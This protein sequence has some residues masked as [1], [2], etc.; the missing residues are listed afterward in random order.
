MIPKI[1][2]FC[3]LSGDRYPAKIQYC[4]DSWKKALPD[5]EI[6]LWDLN[7]F[8]I[9][10]SVW[11]KEAFEA[12]KYAFA[13]D[14]IRCLALYTYGGI[15]LDSDVEV[16]KPFDDLLTLPYF[17]GEEQ[18]GNLEPAVMGCEKGWPVMKKMLEY[19]SGRHFVTDGKFDMETL[20]SLMSAIIRKDWKY[21]RIMKPEDFINLPDEFC[22]FPAE[23]FSPKF[24]N[25]FRCPVTSATYSIHHFAASWYPADKK[26][27]RFVR[28]LF[29]YGVAHSLSVAAKSV[30]GFFS[31]KK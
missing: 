28:R 23:Y 21:N 17:I 15:Y 19:Y 18:G 1:I 2:H 7:R 24:P 14:Y 27:F 6:W 16:L 30:M 29:G 11:C 20:P 26:L 31:G 4:I 5:Y 10:S 9:S 3:W 25:G 13:A 8:D 12:R 22:V